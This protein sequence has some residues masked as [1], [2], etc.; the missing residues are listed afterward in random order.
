MAWESFPTSRDARTAQDQ[1]SQRLFSLTHQGLLKRDARLQ[2]VPDACRA[3][4]WEAPFTEL[5]FDFPRPGA[6][7]GADFWFGPGLPVTAADA[8]DSLEALR[9]PGLQSG[10]AGAFK[11]GIAALWIE[12]R[13]DLDVLHLRLKSP[14]PGFPANLARAAFAITPRGRRG[15]GAPGSGPYR[16]AEE[17]P[18]QRILLGAMRDK[19]E[20]RGRPSPRDLE[21]RAMPDATTRLLALRH[22]SVQASLNNLPADLARPSPRLT[23]RHLPGA[24]LEYVAFNC[25]HPI[26][27]DPRVRRALALA[28]DRGELVKGL[29]GG[30]GR[31]AWGFYPPELAWGVD[32]RTEAGVSP[33]MP[34]NRR[35][36]EALLDQAGL[37]RGSGGL[38]FRLA[39][40]STPEV[41]ARMKALAL[42]D[43]WRKVGVELDVLTR[44]FGTLISEV[45]AS[46]FEVV[47]LR[48]VGVTD[49]QMLVDTFHSAKVPPSGFNR[50]K[51]RDPLT[52][53]LLERAGSA[54]D[55]ESRWTL[56]RE[57][58]RRLVHEAPYVFLYWPD[59]VAALAPGF[60]VDLNGAGDFTMIWRA[61]TGAP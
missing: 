1:A 29:L 51:F 16:L 40:T 54:P 48:W 32:A 28:T 39:L 35:S 30:L 7:G 44:E 27:R 26:L 6:P 37:P 57:A 23:I 50:G 5:S 43:Q 45:M 61:S 34:L 58:Q 36:A 53:R 2:F 15:P 9:D 46:K 4:R 38:R 11:E 10:K 60:D 22:G 24:N 18:E 12:G 31:E 33:D 56:M 49:P 21:L 55:A 17:V 25:A 52:D 47:S 13:G 8:L 3:W 41:Y 19:P 59:Q 14:N 42:Q 20:F